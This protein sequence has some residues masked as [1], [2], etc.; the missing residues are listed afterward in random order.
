MTLYNNA[1]LLQ[2]DK[3]PYKQEF[4]SCFQ[5]DNP[6]LLIKKTNFLRNIDKVLEQ[7]HQLEN[8]FDSGNLACL[9]TNLNDFDKIFQA[10]ND[11]KGKYKKLLIFG[12]GGSSLGAQTLCGTRFYQYS[13]NQDIE[14]KF[15]DNIHYINFIEYLK[16]VDFENTM[17]LIVSKSGQTI[18][19]LTQMVV[20][21]NYFADQGYDISQNV[22]FITEDTDNPINNFA[23]KIKAKNLIHNPKI[24][25]RYSCFS[26]VALLPAAISGFDI[27]EFCDGADFVLN[28]FLEAD[29]E[30]DVVQGAALLLSTE[31]AGIKSN[32]IIPYL[33]RL[34][35]LPFWYAQ[36]TAESLGK[37]NTGMLPIK[38]LGSIDQHSLLQYFLEGGQDL[39]FNFLTIDT[40]N[41]GSDIQ[42]NLLNFAGYEYL[43]GSTIGDVSYAQ[44][45]ATIK[46]FIA[47]NKMLR[48][49]NLDEFSDYALGA[50]MM[51]FVLE[52]IIM[53]YVRDIN[54]F[55]QPAVEFGKKISKDILKLFNN[56]K[57]S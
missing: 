7:K 17:F 23:K 16:L 40:R 18:E 14:I 35:Y 6:K 1:R 36:L 56:D 38:A 9:D 37:N 27:R 50:L 11:I 8:N 20:A 57:H 31:D 32:V 39:F 41:Q 34:Y 12:I 10:V 15:I 25:G 49:F 48:R 42:D 24:G 26:N 46:S 44:Q 45:E 3:M 53:G 5:E 21:L 33:Q 52:T 54:P 51:H 55:D 22:I 43:K 29:S 4:V 19:T 47:K 28:R 2:V 30:N 13:L